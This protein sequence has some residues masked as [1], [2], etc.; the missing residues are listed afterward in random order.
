MENKEVMIFQVWNSSACCK[1]WF[2]SS[3][4]VFGRAPTSQQH[5]TEGRAWTGLIAR[6]LSNSLRHILILETAHLLIHK[7][8]RL[9]KDVL[10]RYDP[11]GIKQ[12]SWQPN[13]AVTQRF[14]TIL[15]PLATVDR[16]LFLTHIS[17]LYITSTSMRML[18]LTVT[19]TEH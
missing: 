3:S 8:N 2:Y 10:I 9:P 4:Y 6:K 16:L 14:K 7:P 5:V 13:S 11:L 19:L 15:A 17:S 12:Y 1:Y 18:L